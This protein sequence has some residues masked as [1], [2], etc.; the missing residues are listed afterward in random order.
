MFGEEAFGNCPERNPILRAAVV[1]RLIG[2]VEIGQR[3]VA[4]LRLFDKG[5]RLG[6]MRNDLVLSAIGHE[7]WRGQVL[8]MID[9]GLILKDTCSLGRAFIGDALAKKLFV[10]RKQTAEVG[11]PV[12]RNATGVGIVGLGE[13]VHRHVAAVGP[14]EDADAIFVGDLFADRPGGDVEHIVVGRAAPFEGARFPHLLAHAARTAEFHANDRVPAIG[15]QLKEKLVADVA[16]LN[17]P[18][19][20]AFGG[21]KQINRKFDGR[22]EAILGEINEALWKEAG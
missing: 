10:L 22:L 20:D 14:A 8:D 1:V 17:E 11:D 21:F 9:G 4:G 5:I 2:V 13:R 16:M 18:P 12:H 7:Q 15:K 19:F 3:G 6:F